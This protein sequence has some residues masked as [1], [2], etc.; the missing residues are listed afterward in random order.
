MSIPIMVQS[1]P[2]TKDPLPELTERQMALYELCSPAAQ[3]SV[4]TA[5]AMLL[6]SLRD[7]RWSLDKM[8]RLLEVSKQ[9]VS[10][11]LTRL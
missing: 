10:K 2:R 5:R 11:A 3:A 4:D 8:A 1:M 7:S 6:R 9:A